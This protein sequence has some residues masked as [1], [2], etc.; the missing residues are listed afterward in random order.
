MTPKLLGV[1]SF[2]SAPPEMFSDISLTPG[3]FAG[4]TPLTSAPRT[5]EPEFKS[6]CPCT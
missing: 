2:S 1:K 4:S 6:P 3:S 5:T